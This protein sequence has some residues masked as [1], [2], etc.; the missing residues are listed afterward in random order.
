M[1]VFKPSDFK[2]M[3]Q[4][5]DGFLDYISAVGPIQREMLAT[6]AENALRR[7]VGVE[8]RICRKKWMKLYDEFND[9]GNSYNKVL[10]D[11]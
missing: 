5:V 11:D 4:E 8:K 6:T 1:K 7:L 9:W 10:E 2:S 3:Y